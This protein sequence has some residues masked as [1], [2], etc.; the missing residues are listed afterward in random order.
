MVPTD[1]RPADRRISFITYEDIVRN[2]YENLTLKDRVR[3]AQFVL[4]DLAEVDPDKYDADFKQPV[5]TYRCVRHCHWN[6]Q[7]AD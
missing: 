1:A 7:D 6:L 3:L 2:D 4:A 5:Y